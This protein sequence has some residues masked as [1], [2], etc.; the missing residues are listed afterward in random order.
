MSIQF[1]VRYILRTGL[2]DRLRDL[3]EPVVL[4]AWHDDELESELRNSGV[5]AHRLIERQMGKRYDRIRSWMNVLHKKQLA[6]PSETVW[7]RR[8]DLERS[9]YRRLRRRARKQ[10]FHTAFA[11]PGSS[12]WLH[13]KERE[14]WETDTNVNEVRAQIDQLRPD[15]AF[16]LTPFLP[17]EEMALRVCEERGIPMCTSILSFDNITTRGWWAVRFDRYM[18]WNHHNATELRRSYPEIS[19]SDIEIVG[20]PQFDFY[21]NP[22]FCWSEADWRRQ[23]SLPPDRPVILFAGGYF[24]CAP[25]EPRF[26]QQI[27]EAIERGEIHGNPV[28]L[29]RNH[30]IDPIERWLPILRQSRHIV[31][32]D[33]FPKGRVRGHSNMPVRDI[34]KLASCLFHSRVHINIAS[35]MAVDGAI[36][37]RPQI[38]PAYDDTPSRKYEKTS[39]DLYFQ[40]H[41][42]PITRS[43]GLEIVRSREELIQA[44]RSAL[45]QPG[46]LAEGRKRLV[47]EICSFD[48]GRATDRVARGVRSFLSERLPAEDAVAKSA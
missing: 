41:Y 36:F 15:A 19:E 34:Q 8:A 16:S 46:R 44:V 27:D 23:L 47:R 37:D 43:G 9:A 14:L 24:F 40:E 33:P 25:H 45:E 28:I 11:I 12:D 3:V 29:F 5:E 4:L 13:R 39:L 32:D 31:Y 38:A 26:L 22:A 48:D 20:A 35:T 1:S 17:A 2:L 42:L 6:T 30:P 7:E 21:W 18:V 10:A